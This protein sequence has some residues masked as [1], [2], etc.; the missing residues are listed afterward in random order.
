MFPRIYESKKV[1]YIIFLLTS[2]FFGHRIIQ[3]KIYEKNSALFDHAFLGC[4]GDFL[5]L[6]GGYARRGGN[7]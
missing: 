1:I 2:S 5:R 7:V 4:V 6:I 3:E